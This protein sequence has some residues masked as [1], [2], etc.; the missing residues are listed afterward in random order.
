MSNFTSTKQ[1]KAD[2]INSVTNGGI[3]VQDNLTLT[4]RTL[5]NGTYSGSSFSGTNTV[6]TGN[7]LTLVDNAASGT[8]AV[9]LN[10][11]TNFVGPPLTSNRTGLAALGTIAS[12]QLLI[13]GGT[14]TAGP[15]STWTTYTSAQQTTTATPATLASLGSVPS[16]GMTMF[17]YHVCAVRTGG[18]AGTAGDALGVE[19]TVVIVNPAGTLAILGTPTQ[20]QVASQAGW[21]V[22]PTISG[23]NLL[24]QVTGALNNNID[25]TLIVTIYSSV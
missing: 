3:L 4:S 23:G 14:F 21:A 25:W 19:G 16:N 12:N 1:I 6:L 20:Y 7:K 9:N 2:Q 11:L 15:V 22:T 8:D 24:L 17:K 10:T 18:T 13:S 5:T